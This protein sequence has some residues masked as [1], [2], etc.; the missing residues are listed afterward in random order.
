MDHVRIIDRRRKKNIVEI[1][2]SKAE[3]GMFPFCAW[4]TSL[5]I[6]EKS[7]THLSCKSPYFH[8]KKVIERYTEPSL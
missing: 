3:I 1:S 5:N 7:A 6:T 4:D 8:K 2:S